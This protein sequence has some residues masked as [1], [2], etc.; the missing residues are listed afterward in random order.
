MAPVWQS[1]AHQITSSIPHFI[2][3]EQEHTC[4]GIHTPWGSEDNLQK[5]VLFFEPV[6]LEGV[7]SGY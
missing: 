7:N 5:S 4:V 2:Y 6:S 1:S 3:V